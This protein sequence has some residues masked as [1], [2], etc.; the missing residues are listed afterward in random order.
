MARLLATCPD[1][2][3]RNGAEAIKYATK[4][5]KL[6]EWKNPYYLSTLAAAYAEVGKFDDAAKWSR[7]A[8]E[9]PEAYSPE[10]LEI[11]RQALRLY[12]ARKPYRED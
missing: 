12:E 5:N 2:K 1:G 3:V 10:E 8:L 9:D 11:E 4:A 6:A 7:R